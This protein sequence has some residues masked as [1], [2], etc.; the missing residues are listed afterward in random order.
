MA[1]KKEKM[2]NDNVIIIKTV[3]DELLILRRMLT[4]LQNRSIDK[5]TIDKITSAIENID[6][7]FGLLMEILK[8]G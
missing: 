8:E 3:I 1:W 2:K 4:I 7:A 5:I 6:K